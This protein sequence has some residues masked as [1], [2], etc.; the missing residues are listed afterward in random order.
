MPT[1]PERKEPQMGV[2]KRLYEEQQEDWGWAQSYLVRKRALRECSDD[3]GVFYDGPVDIQDIYPQVNAEI[4]RGDIQL[5]RGQTRRDITHLLK[6]VYEDNSFNT[7][8]PL[9]NKRYN[10]D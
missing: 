6:K 3:D 9:C 7:S 5:R 2:A 8:C 4:T 1:A 10:D